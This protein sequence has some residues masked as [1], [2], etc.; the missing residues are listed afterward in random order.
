MRP[1]PCG[2]FNPGQGPGPSL[3]YI[4]LGQFHQVSKL[5]AGNLD[6]GKFEIGNFSC[7]HYKN[8][9]LSIPCD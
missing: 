8:N 6:I 7:H 2:A 1:R 3:A 9:F 4:P 5:K